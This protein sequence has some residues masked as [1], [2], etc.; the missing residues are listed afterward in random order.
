MDV[1]AA[2]ALAKNP[3]KIPRLFHDFLQQN[4]ERARTQEDFLRGLLPHFEAL[5]GFGARHLQRNREKT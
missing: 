4:V 2:D 3:A 5:I 1:I